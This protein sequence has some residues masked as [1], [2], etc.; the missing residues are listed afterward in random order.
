[1]LRQEKDLSWLEDIVGD[2]IVSNK[3]K[4]VQE[5]IKAP[6]YLT[7][8]PYCKHYFISVGTVKAMTTPVED[9]SPQTR[10]HLVKRNATYEYIKK[11]LG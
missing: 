2:F 10:G 5:V 8:R 3:I 1:M 11:R 7:T 6:V 4:T 9:L